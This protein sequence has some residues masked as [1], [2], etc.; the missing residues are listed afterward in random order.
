MSS[1][2]ENGFYG[3]YSGT[4]HLLGAKAK[5]RTKITNFAILLRCRAAAHCGYLPGPLAFILES[6]SKNNCFIGIYECNQD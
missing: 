1:C 2:T 6:N 3:N 4:V 5:A